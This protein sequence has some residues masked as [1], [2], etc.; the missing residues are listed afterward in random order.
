[1]LGFNLMKGA[2]TLDPWS[3]PSDCT[4]ESARTIASKRPPK[5]ERFFIPA[6][7]GQVA[8]QNIMA[9]VQPSLKALQHAGYEISIAEDDP[10]AFDRG[11]SLE[12]MAAN[13]A[14]RAFEQCSPNNKPASA[15]PLK[16]LLSNETF[17]SDGGAPSSSGDRTLGAIYDRLEH[18]FK[19]VQSHSNADAEC[20]SPARGSEPGSASLHK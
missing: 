2:S 14:A 6:L 17:K 8:D 16:A 18:T 4:A 3:P 7:G 11:L 5:K 19:P 20:P 13:L 12:L 15:H 10:V 9:V 1:M